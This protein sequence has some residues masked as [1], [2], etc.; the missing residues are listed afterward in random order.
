MLLFGMRTQMGVQP[1]FDKRPSLGEKASSGV[2]L[3][4]VKKKCDELISR[5]IF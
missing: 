2:W 1:T 3:G 4:L 5:K